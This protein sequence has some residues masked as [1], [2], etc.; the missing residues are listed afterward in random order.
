M[1]DERLE[2]ILKQAL[3]P[4]I[5]DSEI[6]IR[7][8]VGKYKMNMK[9]LVAG[10]LVACAALS[11]VVVGVNSNVFAPRDNTKIEGTADAK[12][13]ENKNLFVITAHAAE[14]PEGV[15]SGDVVEISSVNAGYGSSDYLEGRFSIAGQNIQKVKISTDKCNVYSA[16][17][18]AEGDAD[19]EKAQNGE[20][21]KDNERYELVIDVSSEDGGK[22]EVTKSH[23]DHLVN[24][25]NT[26]EGEYNEKMSFGMAI[27]KELWSTNED[28][29]AAAWE[30]IDQIKGAILT[31][32]VIFADGNVETHHYKLDTGKIFV[33]VDENGFCHYDQ[34]TRFLTPEEEAS[35]TA[36]VYGYLMEK[37]D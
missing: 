36:F 29:K 15:N 10:G 20:N 4:E 34:L 16:V 3:A 18:V 8:K 25:G 5:E 11:L 14:L 6:Q 2:Q 19:Y 32:E 27:P 22:T 7:R 24:Q 13:S 21:D 9:K 28:L 17:T 37:I 23:Y 35:E 33:P 30:E 26:Y 12:K 31:I 1:T